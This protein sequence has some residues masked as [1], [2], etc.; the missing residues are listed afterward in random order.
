[1]NKENLFQLSL[2][3]FPGI[4]PPGKMIWSKKKKKKDLLVFW[5][6]KAK[7]QHLKFSMKDGQKDKKNW[8]NIE[9]GAR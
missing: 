1:M 2:E 7:D 5:H 4:F 3:T 9:A 6:A 8:H